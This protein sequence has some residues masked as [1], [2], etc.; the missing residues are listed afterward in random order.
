MIGEDVKMKRNQRRI[1]LITIF[2]YFFLGKNVK[3]LEA[4]VEDNH[5]VWTA[6]D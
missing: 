1:S 6:R 5:W 4:I 2:M 3:K